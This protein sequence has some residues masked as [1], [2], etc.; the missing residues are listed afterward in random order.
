MYNRY[1]YKTELLE[2]NIEENLFAL[3]FLDT[4][5]KYNH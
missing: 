1:K 5:P 3:G 2:E 4:T